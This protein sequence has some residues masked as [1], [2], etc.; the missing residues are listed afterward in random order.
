MAWFKYDCKFCDE[1]CSINVF[2]THLMENH[3]D[4][5]TG[6]IAI[7]DD[8]VHL[9]GVTSEDEDMFI[10]TACGFAVKTQLTF[11]KHL[12]TKGIEHRNRH[13][14]N[15]RVM[16]GSDFYGI[17]NYISESSSEDEEEVAQPRPKRRRIEEPAAVAPVAAPVQQRLALPLADRFNQTYSDL[18]NIYNEINAENWKLR[19]ENNDLLNKINDAK[20]RHDDAIKLLSKS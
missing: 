12:R 9:L 2:G 8:R 15:I 16:K 18:L 1:T 6:N 3:F 7:K 19:K 13:L 14:E 4:D 5:M 10:C 17:F 11:D 20:K